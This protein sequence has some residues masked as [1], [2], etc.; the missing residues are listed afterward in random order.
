M[1]DQLVSAIEDAGFDVQILGSEQVSSVFIQISVRRLILYLAEASCLSPD[2]TNSLRR[3]RKMLVPMLLKLC[4]M[5]L[6]PLNVLL[7]YI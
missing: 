4:S 3:L 5:I 6:R 2:L 7:L 1:Q